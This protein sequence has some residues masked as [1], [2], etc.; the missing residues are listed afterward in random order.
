MNVPNILTVLRIILGMIVPILMLQG[1]FYVRIVAAVF[2]IIAGLTDF[3][4]GWYARKYNL[5]T[6]LGKI[7]DPIADKVILLGVFFVLSS[8]T[9]LNVYSLW[10]VV[11]I[12]LR[13]ILVTLSRF[14]LLSKEQPVVVAASWSGKAKTVMHFMTI[15]V[16][17]FIFMF[18]QY[19]DIEPATWAQFL[20]YATLTASVVITLHSGWSFFSKNWKQL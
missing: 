4:D 17:Y 1:Q 20:L 13:E 6:K 11:P 15:P 16:A 12:F 14:V 7:L 2:F 8:F 10:W 18:Q 3:V 5:E 19:G 9:H